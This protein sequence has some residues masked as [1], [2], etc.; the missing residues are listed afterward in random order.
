MV[1]VA[2]WWFMAFAA[3]SEWESGDAFERAFGAFVW[4][5]AGW[6]TA[7]FLRPGTI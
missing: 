2:F 1:S 3:A 4:I 7:L 6:S 5:M